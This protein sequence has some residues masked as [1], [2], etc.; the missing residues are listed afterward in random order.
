MAK[1]NREVKGKEFISR[2]RIKV[3]NKNLLDTIFKEQIEKEAKKRGVKPD[4]IKLIWTTI[5]IEPA[6]E[7]LYRA[8]FNVKGR[9]L[10][11]EITFFLD[12]VSKKDL[13][14]LEVRSLS[15]FC[16]YILAREMARKLDL[17]TEFNLANK[18][19]LEIMKE[20]KRKREERKKSAN[21]NKES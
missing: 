15:R 21:V 7:A 8:I 14:E 10:K 18:E 3:T 9:N 12:R 13:E 17:D 2:I 5:S 6:I 16:N 1:T 4:E 11:E 20:Q 19:I